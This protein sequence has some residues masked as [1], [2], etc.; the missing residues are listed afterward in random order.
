ML[1][2]PRTSWLAVT[3]HGEVLTASEDGLYR[4]RAGPGTTVEVLGLV[5]PAEGY[6]RSAADA[7]GVLKE[8][9]GS[10][11]F[12]TS[13]GIFRYDPMQ[14]HGPAAA[15]I[16]LRRVRLLDDVVP[17]PDAEH[18]LRLRHTQNFVA[19]DFDATA[20][21]APNSVEFR[22]RLEGLSERWSPPTIGRTAIFPNL[23]PGRFS[24]R[25]QARHGGAWDSEAVSGPI[26]VLPAYW[27]TGW[28]RTLLAALVLL[29][30]LA[31]PV[32]RVRRLQRQREQLERIVTARTTELARYSGQ[33]EDLVA[34]RTNELEQTYGA[35]LAR[36]EERNRVA[37]E[38]ARAHSQASLGR[39]AG[40]V[41]HQVNTPLAA[42]KTRLSLLH[43]DPQIGP[44]AESSLRV[45]GRQVDRIAR[46]VRVL[47]GFVRQRELGGDR[48]PIAPL[49]QSV[50]DLYAEAMRARGVTLAV[51]L[52]SEPLVVRGSSEDLQELVLIL[53]EN[54][55]EAVE[56]GGHVLITVE[57]KGETL[58]LMVEDDG[59]GLGEDP[60]RAF[61]P[62]FTTKTTGTG[63][64]LVIAR[65]VAEASG[66]TLTGEN[67]F[68]DGRG[69][70]F[71]LTLPLI[72]TDTA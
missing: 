2:V 12:G 22:Y 35:L 1:G 66:G 71:V 56:S 20:F 8:P 5:S 61:A 29:V 57:R 10:L 50:V 54:A 38:L 34:A 25:V 68:A 11:L 21:P 67:R 36:E 53:T 9:D 19:V 18:P 27:Q 23:P 59:C 26:H 7:S 64:G 51:V 62:F 45:I 63:L 16:H 70:R 43:D 72:Q 44:G 41:A 52:P 47:L 24:L 32:L 69:A 28:F 60:E 4:L 65:R 30:A 33:L 13:E 37:E 48:A 39:L 31:A 15:R 55:R 6:P 17:V 58:R 40:V 46:I 3:E 14:S 49:V 42:M